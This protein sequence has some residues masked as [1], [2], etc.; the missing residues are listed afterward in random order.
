[1]RA[2]LNVPLD[3][4]VDALTDPARRE[5]TVVGVLAAYVVLWTL[6]GMLAKASQDVNYDMAMVVA[7]SREPALGYANHPPLA[8]WLVGAWFALLPVADWA[9]YLLALAFAATALWAAWLLFARFLDAEKRV[10]ALALLTLVPFYNFHALKF[11]HN[12]VLV[13]LWAATTLWFMRSFETRS[14]GWAALAGAGAAAAMLGKYWSIFLLVGLGLAALID[15]RRGAYFRS[16]APWITVGV[17]ALV[18]APHIAWLIAHDFAPYSYVVVAHGELPFANVAASVGGYLAGAAGYAAVPVLLV[19]AASRPGLP[20]LADMM[21][22]QT[23]ERRLA[24]A[25]FWLPLLLPAPVAL[26]SGLKLNPIWTMSAWTLL[27]VVLLSSPLVSISRSAV[28]TIVAI[29]VVLPP[30][31]IA[32][33]PVIAVGVHRAGLSPAAAHARLLAER[34]AEEWRRTT[35]RPLL[36][37]GGDLDLAFV[38]AFYLPERP[39]AFPVGFTEPPFAP[40]VDAERIARQGISLACYSR[41]DLQGGRTCVHLPVALAIEAMVAQAPAGRR[42]EVEITRS[43]LGTGGGPTRYLIF[44]VP[45]RP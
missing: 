39:S 16:G 27:P 41:D 44:T 23:P 24:A 4:L 9:Y 20:A 17:G 5:R 32:A 13:P 29:A 28:R 25:A 22:P 1:M 11:D 34:M 31:M 30:L 38:T 45:P 36:L 35:E 12:A 42:V 37:V 43:Y 33:A 15:S 18:L 2:V 10:V 3:R 19:L 14:I 26:A 40:W 8:A 7:W 6:Y 21:K